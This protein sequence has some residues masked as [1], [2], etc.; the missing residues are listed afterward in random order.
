MDD[1]PIDAGRPSHIDEIALYF[2]ELP[3]VI[4]H[5][6]WPWVEEAIAVVSKHP[7]VYLGTSAHSPKYW[8]PEMVQFLNSRRGRG[9]VLF[10]TDYPIVTHAEAIKQIEELGL[11]EESKQALLHDVAAKLFKLD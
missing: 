2:P 6:G 1:M 9:K 3:I 11:R 5:T 7:N 4:A 10:G 8:K